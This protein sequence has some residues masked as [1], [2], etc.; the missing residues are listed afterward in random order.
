MENEKTIILNTQQ[1]QFLLDLIL[2][3]E[4]HWDSNTSQIVLKQIRNKLEND[5]EFE[6]RDEILSKESGMN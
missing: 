2:Y 5:P 4:E 1:V 6:M 3:G